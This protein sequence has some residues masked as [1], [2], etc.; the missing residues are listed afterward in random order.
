VGDA[1]ALAD[2][3]ADLAASPPSPSAIAALSRAYSLEAAVAGIRSAAERV[4]A[5]A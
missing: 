2:A 4:A 1:A 5:P 3:I